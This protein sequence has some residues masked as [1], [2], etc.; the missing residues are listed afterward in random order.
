MKLLSLSLLAAVVAL[1]PWLWTPTFPVHT[2]GG[3][4]I[5]GASSGARPH[6]ARGLRSSFPSHQ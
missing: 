3:I 5:T 1:G 4:V 2:S 6:A